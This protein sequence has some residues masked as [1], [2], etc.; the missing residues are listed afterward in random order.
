VDERPILKALIT[1]VE[2][3]TRRFLVIDLLEWEAY[4]VDGWTWIALDP[5]TE[6][7]WNEWRANNPEAA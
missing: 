7:Q 4:R 1:R 6:T 2:E 3:Y 5:E